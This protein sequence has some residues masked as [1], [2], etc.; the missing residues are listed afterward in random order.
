MTQVVNELKEPLFNEYKE[1]MVYIE[2]ESA[3]GEISI[4]SG[5]HL[6]E[7]VIITAKHVLKNKKIKSLGGG[8]KFESGPYFHED[9][10]VDLAAF[11]VNKK[12]GIYIPLGGHLDAW[13]NDDDF[14]LAKTV[15]MGYPLSRFLRNHYWSQQP[16]KLTPW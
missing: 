10:S 6:G 1:A 3:D 7:G 2:V 12:D 8:L 9:D 16:Q 11:I 14:I 4:G 5:F 13:I 15:I